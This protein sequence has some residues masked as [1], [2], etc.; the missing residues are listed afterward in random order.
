MGSH[1]F[2]NELL[3][4][5]PKNKYATNKTEL[6]YIDD[7]W[8]MDLLDL[9]N[10]GLKPKKSYRIILVLVAVLPKIEDSNLEKKC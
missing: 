5:P 2:M 6:F 4:C 1:A 9:N 7:S 10:F 8:S 3:A